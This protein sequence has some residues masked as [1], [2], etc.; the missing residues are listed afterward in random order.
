MQGLRGIH[1]LG[2]AV[3]GEVRKATFKSGS[4]ETIRKWSDRS[5]V[6]ESWSI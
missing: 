5:E 4:S 3:R 2:T 6:S 1:N